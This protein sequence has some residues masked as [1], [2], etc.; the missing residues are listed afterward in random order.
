MARLLEASAVYLIR[1][2][3]ALEAAVLNMPGIKTTVIICTY[4][5]ARSVADLLECLLAQE[6]AQERPFE[7][8]VVDNNSKDNTKETIEPYISKFQ[9][10]LRYFFEPR[11]GKSFA[12]NLGIRESRGEVL[13]FTDDDCLVPGD[14]I[15]QVDEVFSNYADIDFIGGMILPHWGEEKCPSWLAETLFDTTAYEIG[16]ERYW[17]RMFFRG[18]LAILDYGEKPARLDSMQKRYRSFLFYG[19]NMAIKKSALERI[20]GFA[21]DRVITQDT[22]ICLR[23]VQSGMKGLYA[24]NVRVYH[25]VQAD[26]LTPE[27]YQRWYFKRGQ[28]LEPHGPARENFYHPLAKT[29]VFFIKSLAARSVRDRIYYR[30]RAFFNL[31]QMAQMTNKNLIKRGRG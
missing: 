26:K 13:A 4:N 28:F 16:D 11:Q 3:L 5:R 19:P 25:R 15:K 9:G 22:E 10:G 23:L 18:P 24:P 31:A 20:G 14:Y 27:F 21:A 12:L 30:C 2:R 8:L 29:C 6:T 7:I 17:R 1:T